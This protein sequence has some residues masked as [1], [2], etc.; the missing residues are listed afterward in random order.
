MQDLWGST[1]Y[2][3]LR[4][5]KEGGAVY[6]IAPKD[7]P[8][9]IK[10]VHHTSL[11]A[12]IGAESPGHVVAH[13]PSPRDRLASESSCEGDLLLLIPDAA[14][15]STLPATRAVADTET[16]SQVPHHPAGLVPTE[17]GPSMPSLM[18]PAQPSA[19]L[20]IPSTS[21]S[22]TSTMAP[23]RSARSTAGQHSNVHRVP[24]PVGDLALG[25]ANS[26]GSVSHTVT[27]FFRPWNQLYLF[28]LSS[29]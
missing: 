28:C 26:Q 5:P 4:V 25:S 1:V 10:H 27:A 20:V 14:P 7:D 17:P 15:L 3:V 29:G 19:P 18:A 24:R 12:V 11:K 22:D 8:S 6:T 16:T 23:R 9:K 2:F 13:H 21:S